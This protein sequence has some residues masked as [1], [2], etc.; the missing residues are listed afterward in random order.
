MARI[1]NPGHRPNQPL[2]PD[3][4]VYTTVQKVSDFLQLP[5]PDA[6]ALSA[7]SSIN[8]GVISIPI[9]G[10]EFRRWGFT[11]GDTV[12]V[13]SDSNSIGQEYALTGTSAAGS[14]NVNLLATAVGS[15]SYTTADTSYVQHL[16]G[17]TASKERGIQKSQVETL[18]KQKQDYIDKICRMS[19]R[20]QIAVDE[21][22]NFT[23]FKPYR[24]RY[25][26]DYV[27]AVY[28]NNRSVQQILRLSVWQGDYY[29]ELASSRI[30]VQLT[31]AES[32]TASEK[33]FLCPGANGVATLSQGA[34][35]TTWDKTFGA[36]TVANN[37]ANLIN[38]DTATNRGVIQIGSLTEGVNDSGT[39]VALN[40]N[41]EFLAT[42]NSDQGDGMLVISS[43]RSTEDGAT[44]TIATTNNNPCFI[45][46]KGTHAVSTVSSIAGSNF[47]IAN[48]A[49]TFTP[50]H[51]LMYIINDSGT[52]HV[53]LCTRSGSTFTIVT[54]LT[55][56]FA[57]NLSGATV[58]QQRMATD[59]SDEERQKDWWSM[60]D[61][62]AIMF[63][64][65][66]PFFENHSLK[67][68]YVFG[69]RYVDKVI[70]NVCTKLVAMDILLT[71]DYSVM[72]PEG[73]SGMDLSTK[74]QR[75]DE[76]VKRLL[77]PFQE[78]I[79]VAGMG[80]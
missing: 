61:N 57:S 55:S 52:D 34:T 56:T 41:D 35:A 17:I 47:T 15:E 40:I 32:L 11:T 36:K 46:S 63:N 14:G 70:E 71:D 45:Y 29:R 24:R 73:T 67:I 48:N 43:M 25:Y 54:D 76:E 22:Q 50:T 77:I 1:F 10:A 27:G 3:D 9:N 65:E 2:Y 66:Y 62:G 33:I 49:E 59:V 64:N 30:K 38:K 26:T 42:A 51:G 20:P 39:A 58:N 28:L 78:S 5:L 69:E 53:A 21:Y 19:W 79:I 74:I 12:L 80:G 75:M 16:S 23:T 13:Y 72:F 7:N 8:T 37:I 44:A 68:S 31:N 6:V 4:L 18:I 60:E